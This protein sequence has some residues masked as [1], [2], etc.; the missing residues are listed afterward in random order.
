MPFAAFGKH[1]SHCM[2]DVA[3]ITLQPGLCPKGICRKQLFGLHKGPQE[4]TEEAE[5]RALS[6]SSHGGGR[7]P[8]PW[9]G[10]TTS[11]RTGGTTSLLL[12]M[13]A[14]SCKSVYEFAFL[15][16]MQEAMCGSQPSNTKTEA[17]RP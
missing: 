9:E 3:D 15:S 5:G 17:V 8:P 1:Q 12:L 11:D 2:K 6:R 16:T 14:M 4:R 13:P 7:P 10:G